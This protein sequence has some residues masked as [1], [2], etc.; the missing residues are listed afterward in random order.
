MDQVFSPGMRIILV[1]AIQITD[2]KFF[3]NSL[4]NG[5]SFDTFDL[6]EA[7]ITTYCTFSI[8]GH[9]QADFYDPDEA[10]QKKEAGLSLPVFSSWKDIRPVCF[11]LIKGRHTP[12]SFQFVLQADTEWAQELASKVLSAS[13]AVHLKG[14]YLTVRFDGTSMNCITGISFDTFVPDKSLDTLWDSTA[15]TFLSSL[16]IGF[17]LS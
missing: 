11:S 2:R 9:F 12:K 5:S 17:E 14:L 16:N 6:V 3:M 4:L 13:N 7:A 10:A 8:D 15:Q 1:I